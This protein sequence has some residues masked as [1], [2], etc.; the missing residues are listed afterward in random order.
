MAIPPRHLS[1]CLVASAWL[2]AAQPGWPR[3]GANT[4]V[5]ELHCSPRDEPVV[6][7][8]SSNGSAGKPPSQVQSLLPRLSPWAPKA[9]AVLEQTAKNVRGDR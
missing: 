3:S 1:I 7:S 6:P 5:V 9:R 4:T 2:S 8:G